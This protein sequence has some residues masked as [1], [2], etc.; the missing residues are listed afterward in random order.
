MREQQ[1]QRLLLRSNM[2]EEWNLKEQ[3]GPTYAIWCGW[4]PTYHISDQWDQP[5]A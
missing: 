2:G 4:Q 5:R 1:H 3:D